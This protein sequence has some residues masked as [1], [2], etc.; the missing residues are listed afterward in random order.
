[1]SWYLVF[2]TVSFAALLVAEYLL[3]RANRMLLKANRALHDAVLDLL[4]QV[5]QLRRR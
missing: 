2:L 4:I 3:I 5:D 1:M